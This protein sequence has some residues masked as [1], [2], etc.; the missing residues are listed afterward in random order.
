MVVDLPA[1]RVP[2]VTLMTAD[3]VL[4]TTIAATA[5]SMMLVG[6]LFATI[7]ATVRLPLWR[8]LA[9]RLR[10]EWRYLCALRELGRLD[11]RELD[12]LALGRGDLPK[13][14]RDHARNTR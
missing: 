13:L 6:T 9:D 2:G 5:M 3:L 11:D 12:E 10:E 14:A 1:A 4:P 7:Y 8:Q